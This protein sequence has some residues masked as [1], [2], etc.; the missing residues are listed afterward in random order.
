[1][2]KKIYNSYKVIQEY[3]G[4]PKLGTVLV[5]RQHPDYMSSTLYYGGGLMYFNISSNHI[6]NNPKFYEK[7]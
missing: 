6:E 1:M 4:S 2:Q 5:G 3:P 7:I